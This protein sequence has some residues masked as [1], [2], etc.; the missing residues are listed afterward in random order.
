M[1]NITIYTNTHRDAVLHGATEQDA[2]L[3]DEKI[4]DYFNYLQNQAQES[5]HSIE[6]ANQLAG[7]SYSVMN[8]EKEGHEFMQWEIA[9]FWTWHN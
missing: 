2:E 9:D 7:Q 3:Y 6:F 8:D 4:N 1:A 5:G